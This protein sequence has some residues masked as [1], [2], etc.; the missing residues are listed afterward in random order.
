MEQN[1]ERKSPLKR[2]DMDAGTFEASGKKYFIEGSLSIERYAHFQ[3]LEKE[4]AYGFTTKGLYDELKKVTKLL[5]KLRFVDCA[6][7]LVN[8][9]RGV[10]KLEERE[11]V[12]LKICALYCNTE[13]EDRAI[14][15]DDMITKKIQDWK[16]EGIDMRDFFALASSSV[17]GLHEIYQSVIRDISETPGESPAASQ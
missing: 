15:T 1:T 6:V 17:N 13:D 5:D 9:T 16:T 3:I 2:I 7:S 10:A 8:L 4:L 12:I 14:I 11:P